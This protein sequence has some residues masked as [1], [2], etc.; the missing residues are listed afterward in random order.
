[1]SDMYQRMNDKTERDE[2]DVRSRDPE[3]GITSYQTAHAQDES[4]AEGDRMDEPAEE[5]NR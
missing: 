5:A 1:M 3:E 2:E 4:M